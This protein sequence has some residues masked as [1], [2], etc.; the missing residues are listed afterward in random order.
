VWT[1]TLVS[2]S[3]FVPL[4]FFLNIYIYN[5]LCLLEKK[6]LKTIELVHVF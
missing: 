6:W 1:F 3:Y 4:F 5:I 2:F